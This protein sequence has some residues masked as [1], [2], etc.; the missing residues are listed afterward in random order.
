MR[1]DFVMNYCPPEQHFAKL[2]N[3]PLKGT[4]DSVVWMVATC[5]WWG[6]EILTAIY[7]G[8]TLNGLSDGCESN[9]CLQFSSVK[10]FYARILA[11][12]DLPHNID[13]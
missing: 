7:L 12:T 6:G 8:R 3:N 9:L 2:G 5:L 13:Q 11:D 4:I 1:A 10:M